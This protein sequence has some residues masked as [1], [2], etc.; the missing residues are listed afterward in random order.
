MLNSCLLCGAQLSKLRP[1]KSLAATALLTDVLCGC[2]FA[3]MLSVQVLAAN[4]VQLELKGEDLVLQ[5]PK[6]P[7]IADIIEVF[8][9]EL[10][11]VFYH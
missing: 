3:E 6:A 10:I 11:R 8:H 9:Q 4:Q 5:T 2:S 7:Q 1:L